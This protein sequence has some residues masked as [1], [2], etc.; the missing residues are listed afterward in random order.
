MIP[1]VLSEAAWRRRM[2]QVDLRGLTPL[3]YG[4]VNPYAIFRLDM[5]TG[6]PID[7]ADAPVA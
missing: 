1:S 5:N 4:H 2:R 6:L 7:P 3:L